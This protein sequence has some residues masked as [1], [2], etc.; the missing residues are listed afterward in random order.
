MEGLGCRVQGFGILPVCDGVF[1]AQPL[2][3][4]SCLHVNGQ[5]PKP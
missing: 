4:D 3:R 1:V 5:D 2:I